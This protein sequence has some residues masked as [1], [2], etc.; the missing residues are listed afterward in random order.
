MSNPP[1]L[2][3]AAS[4]WVIA[5]FVAFAYGWCPARAAS[6]ASRMEDSESL[7]INAISPLGEVLGT[8]TGQGFKGGFYYGL[9]LDAIYDSNF[10][11]EE[12]DPQSEISMNVA[13]WISYG[14]DPEGGAEFSITANYHPVL[15]TYMENPDYNG[16]DQ[17]AD[18]SLKIQG[19]KTLISAHV[20]YAQN[21]GADQIIGEFVNESLFNAGIEGSYQLA[22]RTSISASMTAAMSEYDDSS[23]EGSEIYTAYFGGYWSATERFSIG[24]AIRYVTATSDNTGTR[25]A[26]EFLTQ[27]Q[28]RLREKVQISASLGV[29]YATN[30]REEGDGSVGLTGSLAASY[31]ISEKLAWVGAVRYI[32]V[33]SPSDV[34]YVINNLMISTALNRQLLWGSVEMGLDFNFAIYEQVG[35]VST[36]L[37]NDNSMGAFLSYNRKFFLD[38]LD[39]QS[40]I[41]YMVN[42]GQ[43]DWSQVQVSLGLRIQF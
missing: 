32:T 20:N 30:S 8:T 25:N 16:M 9:G 5:T 13:P 3:K 18:V 7:S 23:I 2:F 22:P 28:Y 17:S 14:S 33:P 12:S 1:R 6:F 38:R 27:A 11:L 24:P 43:E 41:L 42:D 36:V 34:D 35:A 29:E 39:V 40:R 31:A 15:R 19:S 21:S 37:E 4:A 26:W 10:L